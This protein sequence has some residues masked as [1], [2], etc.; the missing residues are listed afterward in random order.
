MMLGL[1]ENLEFKKGFLK[2][3]S[4]K[5]ICQIVELVLFF[6][7]TNC[8]YMYVRFAPATCCFGWCRAKLYFHMFSM[9]L[10]IFVSVNCISQIMHIVFIW[11]LSS[12]IYVWYTHGPPLSGQSVGISRDNEQSALG[13]WWGTHPSY[14]MCQPAVENC[15]SGE[16][17]NSFSR[18]H[19]SY[20]WLCHECDWATNKKGCR[21]LDL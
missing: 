5:W 10:Y 21:V 9:N 18:A 3:L 15:H 17:P 6:I 19:S 7:C 13:K 4:N 8:T 20:R 2:H 11:F 14:S 1:S 12:Y 16:A